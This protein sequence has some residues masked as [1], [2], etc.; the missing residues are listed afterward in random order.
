SAVDT[1]FVA[2][3]CEVYPDGTSYNIQEGML[4]MSGRN[5]VGKKEPTTPGEVYQVRIGVGHTSILIRKGHRIRLHV[6][7]SHFP[8]W[9][10]NLNTGNAVGTDAKGIVAKQTIFHDTARTSYLELP[11]KRG[12]S[13][14]A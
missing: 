8:M 5:F 10:R 1:D 2:K 3:V 6:T 14:Q 12:S 13:K 11:V 9:D 4:R 7:S